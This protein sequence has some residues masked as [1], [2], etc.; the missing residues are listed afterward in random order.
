MVDQLPGVK[1]WI[2]SIFC[3]YKANSNTDHNLLF[4]TIASV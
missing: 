4:L 2:V 1:C 3:D